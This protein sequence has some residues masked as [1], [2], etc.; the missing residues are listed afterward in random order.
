M[1]NAYD[2]WQETKPVIKVVGVG[3]GGTNAVNRMIEREIKNVEFIAINTDVQVLKLSKAHRLVQ[4]GPKTTKGLGAGSDPELGKK[5][6]KRAK[7]QLKMPS[8][9]QT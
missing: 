6:Q 9:E 1:G 5:L 7:K 3:G 2:P 8:M 4:I